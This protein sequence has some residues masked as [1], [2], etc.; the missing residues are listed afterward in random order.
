MIFPARTFTDVPTIF[1]LSNNGELNWKYELVS[2]DSNN[3]L[4]ETPDHGIVVDAVG[5]IYFGSTYG[6]NFYALSSEGELLWKLP[7]DELEYN[8]SPAIGSDGTLY[9]GTQISTF[10]Q[11]HEDNLIAIRDES[12]SVGENH[13]I[14]NFNLSQ[15]YPNPFNPKTVIKYSIPYTSAVKIV[16]YDA[17]GQHVKQLV[18]E[19]QGASN[20][21]IDFNASIYASGVYFYS[22][23][24][25]SV[26]GKQN[27]INTK[28]MILI[29]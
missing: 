10:F 27:Y 2:S 16:I 25:N 15:N 11:N 17:L 28:K 26:D 12:V 1:S 18:N 20:Y 5:S 29:K 23:Y 9:L 22:I 14:Y 24:A 21:E 6:T 4:N 13:K 7:L 8:S 19:V 3:L